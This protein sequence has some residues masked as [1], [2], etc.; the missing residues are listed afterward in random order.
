MSGWLIVWLLGTGAI[1]AWSAIR[2]APAFEKLILADVQASVAPLGV[3]P[4]M[5]TVDGHRVTL[6]GTVA[7]PETRTRLLQAAAA[8]LGVREAIGRFTD[9]EDDADTGVSEDVAPATEQGVQPDAM[10]ETLIESPVE[11]LAELPA[12]SLAESLAGSPAASPDGAPEDMIV[13][14]ATLE[15]TTDGEMEEALSGLPL[16]TDPDAPETSASDTR[17]PD[18]DLSD[19]G[20]SEGRFDRGAAEQH[21]RDQRT[22]DQDTPDDDTVIDRAT[23]A[24]QEAATES[25]TATTV[26]TISAPEPGIDAPT[27]DDTTAMDV[28]TE[29]DIDAPGDEGTVAM[30]TN[31]GVEID[32][33]TDDDIV[34]MNAATEPDIDA[35]GD[36]RAVAPNATTSGVST[37]APDSS[38]ESVT[39]PAKS[40]LPVAET[41]EIVTPTLT[42]AL[43]DGVLTLDGNLP[44]T[45]DSARLVEA[46]TSSLDLDYVSNTVETGQIMDDADW[47]EPLTTLLPSLAQL[48]SPGV[49]IEE[50]TLV[51]SGRA[52]DSTTRDAIMNE[53]NE[54]FGGLSVVGNIE[55]ARIE[56]TEPAPA[57][58]PE[59]DASDTSPPANALRAAWGQLPV[60]DILFEPGS[61][62]LTEG[63]RQFLD[64]IAELLAQHPDVPV[65]IEGHTDNDGSTESNLRL[66]QLRAN[67]VRDHLVERNIPYGQ[68]KSYGYGEGVPIADNRTRAGRAANRRIEFTY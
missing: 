14:D 46:A 25:S 8:S 65:A 41:P 62:R 3:S 67:A 51:L 36:E 17:A 35:P 61:D 59:G 21:T 53:A 47:L 16:P 33:P 34:A 38:S 18:P 48:E 4:L 26:T 54:Q 56:T 5:A 19:Q 24:V 23:N 32:A 30:N 7:E 42:L 37:E 20:L 49:A 6:S 40:D 52:P 43:A 31:T 60:T 63:S 15:R 55:I 58:T 68:L 29:P 28:A 12:E 10:E 27:D 9:S 50:Q 66:S 45:D 11:S 44:S 2:H 1:S 57:T 22:R 64:R 13:A 39:A